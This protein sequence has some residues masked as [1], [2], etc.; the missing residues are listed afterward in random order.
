MFFVE[1]LLICLSIGRPQERENGVPKSEIFAI[2]SEHE[3]GELIGK[4]AG[5]GE[6]HSCVIR[7]TLFFIFPSEAISQ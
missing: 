1:M 7:V 5:L 4:A 2:F 3:H 6:K